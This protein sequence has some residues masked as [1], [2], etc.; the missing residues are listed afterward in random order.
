MQGERVGA[1]MR[2][3]ERETGVSAVLRED[4][5]LLEREIE[6]ER[7][8]DRAIDRASERQR[9]RE[10][11][12]R[13][14]WRERER[15]KDRERGGRGRTVKGRLKRDGRD[16]LR[17]ANHQQLVLPPAA[18]FAVLHRGTSLIRNNPLLE[19]YSRTMPRAIW[20]P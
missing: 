4:S 10:W 14:G 15:E 8:R 11:S 3:R 13:E 7:E 12:D 17:V 1:R 20:W 16:L 6:S 19:P 2:E 5:R 18:S 9:E